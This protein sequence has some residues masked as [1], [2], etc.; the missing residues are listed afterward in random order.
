MAGDGMMDVWALTEWNTPY[1]KI[2][3]PIPEPKGTEVIVKVTH[4]GL[5][6]SD[7]HFYEGFYDMGGGKRFYVKDRGVKL[8]VAGGHEIFGKVAKVGPDAGDVQVGSP[9][10]VYPW[11]GCA[12]CTR[13]KQGLDNLCAAQRGLGTVQNGGMAEY[14][15]VPHPKY[16]VDPGNLDPAVACTFGCAGITTMSAV[17]KIM[18]LPPDD[19]VLLIG[20][21]GVGLAAISMLKAY[22]HQNIISVDIGD[23]K[24]AA[25]TQAGA[26]QVIN[27]SR[28]DPAQAILKAVGGP[29]LSVIDFVNNSKT[30]AMLNGLVGKGAIWVQVGVMGGSV[31][32]SLVGNIFKGLTVYSNITGTLD[33]L[34]EVTR[35]GKEGKL[36]TLP[37]TQMPWDSVND[38]VKL[39]QDG[40]ATGRIVLVKS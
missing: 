5:C 40:K 35:L 1:Q 3:Q 38:A 24:L 12:S 6:H 30:A 25:A 22:G 28:G 39:L 23:D 4:C 10:I 11:L 32:F 13:C 36:P 19:P 37:V 26:T 7:L 27:S 14:V 21:G 29:V 8:P 34:K 9:E 17:S 18:P 16:L 33:H 20:A 2:Q 15:V 31:E